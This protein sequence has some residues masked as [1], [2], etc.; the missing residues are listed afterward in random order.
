[1]ASV[2]DAIQVVMTRMNTIEIKLQEL[3]QT[4]NIIL[5]KIQQHNT[6]NIPLNHTSSVFPTTQRDWSVS[7]DA[8]SFRIS[9]SV[10]LISDLYQFLTRD[11][12]QFRRLH[13]EHGGPTITSETVD[14]VD[15]AAPQALSDAAVIRNYSP[16][17]STFKTSTFPLYS[18]WES[19]KNAPEQSNMDVTN[20]PQETL[21]QMMEHFNNC[22]LC[23]QLPDVEALMTQYKQKI[24]CP[25]LQNAILAW[26]ARHASIYHGMFQGKDPNVVGE[27]FFTT[28]KG[29]LR[30][31]FLE[32]TIDTMHALLVLYIYAIGKSGNSRSQTVSEAYMYLGLAIRMGLDMGLHKKNEDDIEVVIEKKRRLFNAS[33]FLESL[34]SAHAEKPFL[35]PYDYTITC[36]NPR[37]LEHETGDQRYRVEFMIYRQQINK[38]HHE[39]AATIAVEEP[40]ISSI[41]SLDNR[42]KHWYQQ[43]P[44]YLRYSMNDRH[45]DRWVTTSFK[46]QACVKLG[47]EYHF[48]LC[49]LYSTFLSRPGKQ[50]SAFSFSALQT[51]VFSCDMITELLDCWVKLQQSWCHFTIETLLMATLVYGRELSSSDASAANHARNQLTKF[52]T[53]LSEAPVRHHMH[54]KRLMKQ[55][56]DLLDQAPTSPKLDMEPP[57]QDKDVADVPHQLAIQALMNPDQGSE[58]YNEL[59]SRE[60]DMNQFG[61]LAMPYCAGEPLDLNGWYKFTDFLYTPSMIIADPDLE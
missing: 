4:T 25:L 11:L 5:N 37:V 32:P 46:E 18:V 13:E 14:A 45:K 40:K 6:S 60:D 52:K 38:I 21:D 41:L 56:A 16:W 53:V 54:V 33:S 34:C 55:I 9:S 15:D 26:S 49:Q 31:R 2:N 27:Q 28:A 59:Q 47:F 30:T 22:F 58:S 43:L 12:S 36:G 51:C 19:S 23:L 44:S 39:I 17:K 8:P 29:L 3:C 1:M 42:L 48:Q 7:L 50:Y 10:S 61:F 35:F 57:P 24:L 20:L